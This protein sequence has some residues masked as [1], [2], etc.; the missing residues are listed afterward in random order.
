MKDKEK[1]VGKESRPSKIPA[2]MA[3][4]FDTTKGR[5]FQVTLNI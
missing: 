5:D 4:I 2:K 3:G 1:E